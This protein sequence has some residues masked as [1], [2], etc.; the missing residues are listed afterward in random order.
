M[1]KINPS[2]RVSACLLVAM[3][4]CSCSDSIE[5]KRCRDWKV[6]KVTEKVGHKAAEEPCY[7]ISHAA[8]ESSGVE[9]GI[10]VSDLGA[11]Q[12]CVDLVLWAEPLACQAKGDKPQQVA[13]FTFEVP[14]QKHKQEVDIPMFVDP[15]KA[16]M[17]L[18]GDTTQAVGLMLTNNM[19]R[20]TYQLD[21]GT[22]KTAT[23]VTFGLRDALRT[24]CEHAGKCPRAIVE[25]L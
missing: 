25:L 8:E 16:S 10:Q 1:T 4:A 21:G 12:A 20:V 11:G 6:R 22:K 9:L 17:R 19:V 2:L 14:R 18:T 7:C 3:I 5:C 24:A 13:H 15:G 23:F